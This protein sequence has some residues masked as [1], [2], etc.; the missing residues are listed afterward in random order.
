MTLLRGVVA[1]DPLEAGRL[2]V[3][4]VQRRL[5]AIQSG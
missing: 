5:L 2:E 1:V 3:D 4:L